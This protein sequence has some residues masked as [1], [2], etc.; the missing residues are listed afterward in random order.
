MKFFY[1]AIILSCTLLIMH[2][3]SA[4]HSEASFKKMFDGKSLKGWKGDKTYWRVENNTI[5][6]ETTPEKV[7]KVNTFLIYDDAQPGDF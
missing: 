3:A 2:T 1:A 7:L 4:Q 5:I 6:G